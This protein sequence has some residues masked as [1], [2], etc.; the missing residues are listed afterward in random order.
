MNRRLLGFL[1]FAGLIVLGCIRLGFW[2]LDRL[3]QRQSANREIEERISAPTA[4]LAEVMRDTATMAYRSVRVAGRYDYEH[5]FVLAARSRQG[6]PGVNLITPFIR[7][8]S[9]TAILIN[10]GW[11]YSPDGMVITDTAWREPEQLSSLVVGHVERP[12]PA[13]GPVFNSKVPRVIR[14][15]AVDSLRTRVPYPLAAAVVVQEVADK[16]ADG[17]VTHPVRLDSPRLTNG[18]HRSYALQWFAFALIGLIGMVA[19]ARRKR[20]NPAVTPR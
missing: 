19:V 4:S 20:V 13:S 10:R 1:V 8:D 18:P 17:S 12:I 14:R 9:D 16:P 2:Q 6:S 15:L 11:V 3:R 5:E 7:I